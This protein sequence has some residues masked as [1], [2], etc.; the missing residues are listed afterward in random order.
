MNTLW[1]KWKKDLEKSGCYLRF[2]VALDLWMKKMKFGKQLHCKGS[3]KK[4][5]GGRARETSKEKLKV[6]TRDKL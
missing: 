2:W 5:G 4:E 1:I 3:R 6:W